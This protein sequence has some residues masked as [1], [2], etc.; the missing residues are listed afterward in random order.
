MEQ[1]KDPLQIVLNGENKITRRFDLPK[2]SK[3]I[4]IL[5]IIF[6]LSTWI[7]LILII[8]SEK[9]K[10]YLLLVFGTLSYFFHFIIDFIQQQ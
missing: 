2:S 9:E 3:N 8:I 4:D 5:S 6:N 7:F 10:Y 1:K